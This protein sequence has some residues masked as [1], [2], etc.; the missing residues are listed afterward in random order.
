MT[1]A[2]ASA[3]DYE[4]RHPPKEAF[5]V[6]ESAS[7]GDTVSITSPEGNIVDATCTLMCDK[8]VVVPAGGRPPR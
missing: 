5:E 1:A 2:Q 4:H 3:S 6:C 8:L 7:E